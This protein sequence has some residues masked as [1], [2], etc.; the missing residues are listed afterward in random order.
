MPFYV[1]SSRGENEICA[2]LTQMDTSSLTE[3]N[4][5]WGFLKDTPKRESE[6]RS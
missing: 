6:L 1:K 3:S 4:A 5:Y 2:V